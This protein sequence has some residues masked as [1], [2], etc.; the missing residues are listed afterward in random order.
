MQEGG[1]LAAGAV[2]GGNGTCQCK[3]D[4]RQFR[5]KEGDY[6]HPFSIALVLG[7]L[8]PGLLLLFML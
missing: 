8:N 6:S 3:T 4:M 2:R 5:R 1:V 7:V